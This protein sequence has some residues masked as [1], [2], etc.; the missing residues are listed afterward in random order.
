[1]SFPLFNAIKG[2]TAG[3]PGTG[4]FTPNTAAT[5]FQPWSLVPSGW[6]GLVRYEDGTAWELSYGYWNATAITRPGN[7]FVSSSTGSQLSLTSAATAALISDAGA[8]QPNLGQHR[9]IGVFAQINSTTVHSSGFATS[10]STGTAAGQTPAATNALTRQIRV[11]YTS[12]TTANAYAGYSPNQG[13]P[14]STT[15]GLGGVEFCATFGASQLPTGPRLLVGLYSN[16]MSGQTA[17]PSALNFAYAAFTKDSTDTNIQFTTN[18][19]GTSGTKHADTGIPLT[20]NGWYSVTIW[21]P[22]GGGVFYGLLIRRDTGDIWFGSATTDLPADGTNLV[23]NLYG[24]L[25]GADTGTAFIMHMGQMT[26]RT[27]W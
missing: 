27:A 20:A 13:V 9:L 21:T 17:E 14:Y 10:G 8:V 18:A 26:M 24:S 23:P 12:A 4:S 15:A 16:S 3:T 5:G 7:G 22:P 11:Q 6:I 19:S 1:M 25:N 2:T